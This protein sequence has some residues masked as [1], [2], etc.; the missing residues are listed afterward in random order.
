[1]KQKKTISIQF[2][3]IFAQSNKIRQSDYDRMKRVWKIINKRINLWTNK[4]Y[5]KKINKYTKGQ[6]INIFYKY[7]YS[8]PFLVQI[9][10]YN[11]KNS[12]REE[13][14]IWLILY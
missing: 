2:F 10:L 4:Y 14:V 6:D 12:E 8:C 9:E 11:P 5:L 7:I 1:M 13:G 3:P